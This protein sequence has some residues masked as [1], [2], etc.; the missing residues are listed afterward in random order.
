MARVCASCQHRTRSSDHADFAHLAYWH[1]DHQRRGIG[2][3]IPFALAVLTMAHM[4]E[5]AVRHADDGR[6]ERRQ[7]VTPIGNAHNLYL[8]AFTACHHLK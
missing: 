1:A 2:H 5:H 4:E 3:V 8:K 7:H 6:C